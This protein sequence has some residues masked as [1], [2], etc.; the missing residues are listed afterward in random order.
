[1]KFRLSRHSGT[2]FLMRLILL[3]CLAFRLQAFAQV[4]ISE[5]LA[6]NVSGLRDEHGNLSDWVEVFNNTNAPVNL[7]GWF[8]TDSAGNLT[9]WRFP[10]TNLPP[11]GFLVVFAIGHQSGHRGSAPARQLFAERRWRI[12]GAGETRRGH[13]RLGVC[14]AISPTIRRHFLWH[15]PGCAN[16]PDDSRQR[17]RPGPGADERKL[18]P[19]LDGNKLSTTAAWQAATNGVGFEAYVPGFAVR[20][21]RANVGVCDLATALSGAGRSLAPGGGFHRQ[22]GVINYLNTGDDAHFGGGATFPGFTIS[23]DENNFVTE[24]T[25]ILTIPAIGNWTFG[26]NSDDGFRVTI[27]RHV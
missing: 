26:V 19:D 7:D 10:A 11:G 22:P 9:K 3:A 20:N 18:R 27:G 21:I 2:G 16:H 6:N 12:P 23:V 4:I 15:R 14:A 17:Q 13:H 8:L 5:F 24:A 25:G 1:M